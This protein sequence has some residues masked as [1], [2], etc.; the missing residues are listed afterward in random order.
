MGVGGCTCDG[1]LPEILRMASGGMMFQMFGDLCEMSG[2][3]FMC[4]V[5]LVDFPC[6]SVIPGAFARLCCFP[7][8]GPATF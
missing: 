8:V 4:L 3:L 2:G 6:V 5:M 1:G 7:A